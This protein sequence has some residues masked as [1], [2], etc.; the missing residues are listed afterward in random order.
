[1]SLPGPGA[2]SFYYRVLKFR[3]FCFTP[4][5]NRAARGLNQNAAP[6]WLLMKNLYLVASFPLLLAAFI[7]IAA[8]LYVAYHKAED[9]Q[10]V[11]LTGLAEEVLRR[12]MASRQQLVAALDELDHN[13]ELPCTAASMTRMQQ[14]V[15]RSF[16]LQGMGYEKD[17]TLICS[18]LTSG[19]DVVP[20]TGK[21]LTTSSGISA[22]IGGRLPFAPDQPFNIYSRRGHVVIIHPD[23]VIDLPMLQ[24]NTSIGLA[25][26]DHRALIR[27]RGPL[28]AEWLQL[29]RPH[30][31][32][33]VETKTHRIV[34][35]VS[36]RNNLVAMAAAPKATIYSTVK[37]QAL[38]LAPLGLGASA[39]FALG[40][41][42]LTRWQLTL[43][44]RLRGGLRRQEFFVEYQPLVHLETGRWIGAEA[45]LRW[46]RRDGSMVSPDQFISQAEAIG[47]ISLLTRFVMD[48][49]LAD[50]PS[51]LKISPGFHVSLNLSTQDLTSDGPVQ[52]LA[53]RF[54][55]MG[56]PPGAL[57]LEV[58][59]RGVV[60]I[61]A[62]KPALQA[63]RKIG[64]AIA[65]D[66][67]GT[68]Y[69]SLAMLELLDI[70]TLKI[71]RTF[72][73][74][75][76]A[77]AA[78]SPVTVHI[79]EMAKKLNLDLIAEG[80]ETQQQ[81]DFLRAHGVTCGQGWLFAKAMPLHALLVCLRKQLV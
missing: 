22:W 14:L 57:M 32:N 6:V 37:A 35:R 2:N 33:V 71:D 51:L 65:L 10:T 25:L 81:L 62:A 21:P 41:V 61:Q 45:L 28:K 69:S 19:R 54:E 49:V 17:G 66:D 72:I 18:T 76:G 39:L 77:Q 68:G 52:Y 79:I 23:I 56:L 3:P 67:F 4:R 59:E 70:D 53:Q 43:Q 50:L 11:Q 80:V 44:S 7:P 20:L 12:G 48:R 30:S 13:A 46:R 16:Y 78:T 73:A 42:L 60:D 9:D 8:S 36:E 34:F 74:S 29:I 15:G 5:C 1:M 55:A 58:T 40:V 24:E 31:T 64:A 26:L 47:A 63:G 27:S 38:I 75:I